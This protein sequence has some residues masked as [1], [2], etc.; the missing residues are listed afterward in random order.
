MDT[1][2]RL[3][4]TLIQAHLFEDGS[5]G[6]VLFGTNYGWCVITAWGC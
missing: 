1:I 6:I 2:L 4:L 3:I 5:I